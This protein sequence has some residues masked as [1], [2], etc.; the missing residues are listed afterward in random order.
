MQRA[1]SKPSLINGALIIGDLVCFLIFA[2]LGL[3]SHEEGITASGLLRA[4]VPFQ[5]AWL[6]FAVLTGLHRSRDADRRSILKA[7]LPTWVLALVLRSLVFGRPFAPTFA[8]IAFVFNFG[9]L[10][11]WR[12]LLAPRALRKRA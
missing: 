7:W 1:A 6:V 11:L 8:V 3:R 4:A 9:L 2:S 10:F 5:G 12:R